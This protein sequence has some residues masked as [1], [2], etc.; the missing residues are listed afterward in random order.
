MIQP[1]N[2]TNKKRKEAKREK[3]AIM[4]IYGILIFA[5]LVLFFTAKSMFFL[6]PE[7]NLQTSQATMQVSTTSRMSLTSYDKALLID[8]NDVDELAK[9]MERVLTNKK[10][11]QKMR[12]AG[13]EQAKKFSWEKCARETL[14]VY[15]KVIKES[16]KK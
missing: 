11:Q 12:K 9:Q 14:K 5:I 16:K 10:L 3:V 6:K 15:K 13:I 1:K 7:T 8:P 4:F 2:K